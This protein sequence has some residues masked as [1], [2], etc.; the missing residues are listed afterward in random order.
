VAERYQRARKKEKSKILD[1]FAKTAQYNRIYASWLL[2]NLW[3]ETVIY[4]QG[5]REI[6][7]LQGKLYN[8]AIKKPLYHGKKEPENEP[9]FK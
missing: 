6:G 9:A 3:R 4:D 5:E 7:Q 1:E 2:R 8:M